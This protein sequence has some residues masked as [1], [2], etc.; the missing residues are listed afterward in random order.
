MNKFDEYQK[1]MR[2]KHGAQAFF[3]FLFLWVVNFFSSVVLEVQWAETQHT[4]TALLVFAAVAYS[5]V[6]NIYH[7]AYFTKRQS[8]I[9]YSLLFLVTGILNIW[10]SL[11][12]YTPLIE[13]GKLTF[14][15]IIFFTGFIWLSIPLTYLVRSVVEKVRDLVGNR[16]FLTKGVR[17]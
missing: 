7:G 5:I 1:F 13:N 16:V 10:T 2:Y 9:F 8:P 15:S 12:P 17:K 4:E 3:L 14:N 11:S 6:R